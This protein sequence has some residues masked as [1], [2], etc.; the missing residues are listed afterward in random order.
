MILD[1]VTLKNTIAPAILITNVYNDHGATIEVAANSVNN[2]S[3]SHVANI[4]EE[5]TTNTLYYYPG[6]IHSANGL[7]ITGTGRLNVVGDKFGICAEGVVNINEA[8]I[9]VEAPENGIALWT[10]CSAGGGGGRVSTV[11]GGDKLYF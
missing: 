9:N 2:I 3:G 1:G 7:Y 6:A 4:Y 8:T 11:G 10:S 5:G